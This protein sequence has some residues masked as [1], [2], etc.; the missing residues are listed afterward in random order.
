MG[1][2]ANQLSETCAPPL[3]RD[4]TMSIVAAVIAAAVLAQPGQGV[5]QFVAVPDSVVALTNVRVIDGTGAA[6][7]AGQTIVMR[8]GTIHTIGATG[9]V[10]I[11]AGA[12]TLDLAGRTV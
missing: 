10:T 6:A 3:T 11:P 8:G 9:Q 12:R 4:D 1:A 7:K 2:C 5:R